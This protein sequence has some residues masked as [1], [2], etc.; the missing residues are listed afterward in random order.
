MTDKSYIFIQP[1]PVSMQLGE[2]VRD[3]AT[4]I[5]AVS[6]GIIFYKKMNQFCKIFLCQAALYLLVDLLAANNGKNAWIYNLYIP[7]ETALLFF[8]AQ[9]EFNTKKSKQFLSILYLIF[10]FIYIP[11]LIKVKGTSDLVYISVLTEYLFV[12]GIYAFLL[13]I[14]LNPAVSNKIN[15]SVVTISFGLI[16]YCGGCIPYLAAIKELMH[17]NMLLSKDMFQVIVVLLGALRYLMLAI[18]YCLLGRE[19]VYKKF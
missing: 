16:I 13:Y 11:E 18:G 5:L 7:I 1:L 17:I 8:A 2:I 19:I 9:T 4:T 14:R 12:T 6:T 3:L 10:L 15:I